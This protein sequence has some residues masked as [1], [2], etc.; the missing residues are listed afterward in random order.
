MFRG[1]NSFINVLFKHP[2]SG[3]HAHLI[4]KITAN[5]GGHLYES[6]ED[7]FDSIASRPEM[8]LEDMKNTKARNF[9]RNMLE[10]YEIGGPSHWAMKKI[11]ALAKDNGIELILVNMP[12]TEK[13]MEIFRYEEHAAY[14]N[15]V[16]RL[17]RNHGLRFHDI[18]RDDVGL[19]QH[20]FADLD[21]LNKPGAEKLSRYLSKEILGP[22]CKETEG[23]R[24]KA[25]GEESQR[26]REIATPPR[27]GK[28]DDPSAVPLPIQLATP[29][30]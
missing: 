3:E 23:E 20:D 14:I 2:A 30:T 27:R 24:S 21:H 28:S 16:E 29:R 10:N 5:A 4:A 12:V 15:Y 6:A 17:S 26:R 9:R 19:T 1:L 22:Q 8:E 18:A 25:K 7:A 13:F 11:I